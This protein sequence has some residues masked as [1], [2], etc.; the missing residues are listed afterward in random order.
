[1]RRDGAL[2]G[3]NSVIVAE[4]YQLVN[5][6]YGGSNITAG[7]I[8]LLV[9]LSVLVTLFAA[10]FAYVW[11]QDKKLKTTIANSELYDKLA[12][13]EPVQLQP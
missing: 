6:N 1:M 9:L 11:V 10:R 13:D 4:S 5:S 2:G 3:P 7:W 8:V 12:V